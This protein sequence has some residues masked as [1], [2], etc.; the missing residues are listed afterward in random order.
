MVETKIEMAIDAG[1]GEEECNEE[2]AKLNGLE[3][4][5]M[6]YI[7]SQVIVDL[8]PRSIRP[9]VIDSNS[10]RGAHCQDQS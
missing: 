6:L 10:R 7:L 8:F 5:R 4:V 3:H 1:A 2:D 9:F